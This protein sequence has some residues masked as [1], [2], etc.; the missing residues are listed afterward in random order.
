M[1]EIGQKVLC[2]DDKIRPGFWPDLEGLT[3]GLVYTIRAFFHNGRGI[4]VNE[5]DS[6]CAYLADRFRTLD[7]EALEVFREAAKSK[8]FERA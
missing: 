7:D 4:T 6:S 3:A 8:C 2:I 5:N 1:L